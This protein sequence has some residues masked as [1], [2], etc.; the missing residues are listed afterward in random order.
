M[1]D[2]LTCLGDI[3]TR[4]P[5]L[6]VALAVAWWW[7]ISRAWRGAPAPPDGE[8]TDERQLGAMVIQ[9]QVN[10]II[11]GCSIIIAGA[12]TFFAIA[13]K[14]SGGF[15]STHIAWAGTWAVFGLIVALYTTAI[16]PPKVP[17]YNV[18]RDK[19]TSLACAMALFFPLA[20]GLRFAAGL[21]TYLQ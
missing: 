14:A 13:Q 3:L 6:D 1:T 17:R 18:V 16:L 12:G 2:F 7:W 5:A 4:W 8:K 21:W 20:A 10:G 9:G 15:V 11:T 19:A